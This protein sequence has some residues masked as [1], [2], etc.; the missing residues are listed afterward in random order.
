MIRVA[1]EADIPRIVEL[2]RH[3][4]AESD[5]YAC[6]S[7][8][9]DKVAETMTGLISQSGVIFLY[10]RDGEIVG[11]LAGTVTEFWFSREKIACDYSLFIEPAHRHGLIAVRLVLAFHAWS[12]IMGARQIKMGVTTGITGA[13]R[14]YQSLG[15]RHCGNLFSKDIEHGN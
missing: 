12:K 5:E 13:D 11:G 6:I 15:M 4:H 14:L 3:L 1:T 8:D 7:Y 2:G 10:E 9:P